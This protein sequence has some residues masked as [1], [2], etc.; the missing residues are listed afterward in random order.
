MF[1]VARTRI[2]DYD[3]WKRAFDAEVDARIRHGARGHQVL[4]AERDGNELAVMI[5]V[6]SYGGAEGLMKYDLTHVRAMDR[7]R[8]DSG[9]HRD[10]WRIDYL[11]EVDTADYTGSIPPLR[12]RARPV[13]PPVVS[14]RNVR[15]PLVAGRET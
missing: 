2:A 13:R 3:T 10:S 4:R 11:D 15:A 14:H 9:S 5:E 7:G 12:S 1:V 8:V 6:A